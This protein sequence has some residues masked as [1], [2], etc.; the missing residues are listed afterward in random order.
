MS[1]AIGKDKLENEWE[2]RASANKR[3]R[4]LV[5]PA[6][7][8]LLT[9][10]SGSPWLSDEEM[11]KRRI[12]TPGGIPVGSFYWTNDRAK[13]E[14]VNVIERIEPRDRETCDKCGYLDAIREQDYVDVGVG[15]QCVRDELL[16]DAC[17]EVWTNLVTGTPLGADGARQ[18]I[19]DPTWTPH[20]KRPENVK[21]L[22]ADGKPW[23]VSWEEA[24]FW[25]D[26][27]VS[28]GPLTPVTFAAF[29]AMMGTDGSA[30][31][32]G[33]WTLEDWQEAADALRM[34]LALPRT[35]GLHPYASSL[36]GSVTIT[37]GRGGCA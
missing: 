9:S 16:C 30:F 1:A 18:R 25:L 28:D 8:A 27:V 29:Q 10:A 3:A 24:A 31:P 26:I 5:D 14:H 37:A 4:A 19:I 15:Q 17:Q 34:V 33:G 22:C 13:G 21:V 35:I 32:C 20:S 6:G 12:L 36:G 2:S 7:R 23:K 11:R